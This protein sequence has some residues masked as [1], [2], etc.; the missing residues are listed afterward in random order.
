GIG[1]T[2]GGL[3][4][5]GFGLR[6]PF[7][8]YGVFSALACLVALAVLRET[9]PAAARSIGTSARAV[10][11]PADPPARA[12]FT[13]RA[14]VLIGAV[15]FVQFW[16]RTGALFTLVPLLGQDRIGLS[17]T[18][19]GLAL[20]LPNLLNIAMLYH[21]GTLADRYGRK[22]VIA[23]ATLVAGASMFLFA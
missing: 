14:F 6:A 11:T 4:K 3:L 2:P 15:S 13:S 7:I 16:A 10:A 17:A 23:P 1:P 21:A 12:V 9:R 18:R 22:L 5:D 20:T 8:A 19:V